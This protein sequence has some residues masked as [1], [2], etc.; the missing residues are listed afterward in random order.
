MRPRPGNVQSLLSH[1]RKLFWLSLAGVALFA[2][3]AALTTF[4][5]PHVVTVIVREWRKAGMPAVAT[6]A[7]FSVSAGSF[8][9]EV[10]AATFAAALQSSGLPIL[11]RF[12]PE[13]PDNRGYQVL[14]G[15]YV[16]TDEAEHAQRAL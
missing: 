10:K 8:A 3:D 16:S 11:V 12:R 9:T 5:P 6:A 13:D 4:G 15:P 14:V 2:G 1:W 7:S